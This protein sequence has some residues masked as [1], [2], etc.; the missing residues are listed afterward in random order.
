MYERIILLTYFVKHVIQHCSIMYV[1]NLILVLKLCC[2]LTHRLYF[3]NER[4]MHLVVK[5]EC[6][7]C[8]LTFA[9]CLIVLSG[10]FEIP[11]FD[12]KTVACL[13]LN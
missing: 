10:Y 2:Y 13:K 1:K 4:I 6:N 8:N 3:I 7:S 9:K 5:S 11:F 12:M